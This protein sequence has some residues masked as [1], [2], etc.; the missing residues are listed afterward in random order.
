MYFA[1]NDVAGVEN[2]YLKNRHFL[3]KMSPDERL[4]RGVNYFAD[5][6][7]LACVR[8]GTYKLFVKGNRAVSI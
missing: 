2:I 1:K 8:Y 6:T 5:Q 4:K 7:H 3:C